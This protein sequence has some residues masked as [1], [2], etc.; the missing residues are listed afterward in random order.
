MNL[1]A[2]ITINGSEVPLNSNMSWLID[3]ERAFHEDAL[4]LM[5]ALLK[6]EAEN[7]IELVLRFL[8]VMSDGKLRIEEFKEASESDFL[9]L[10][11]ETRQ[12]LVD[13]MTTRTKASKQDSKTEN[14]QVTTLA[15]IA[16]G[17]RRGLTLAD[18]DRLTMGMWI[19]YC[20]EHN[21][22]TGVGRA[23]KGETRTAT[24]ADFDRF[25]GG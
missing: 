22:L 16:S 4:S 2:R 13:S 10:Y 8:F 24:Q 9:Y 15:M 6:G 3:Y 17:I 18:T 23:E 1:G 5:Y 12:I 20:I 7:P 19:D 11:Q 25:K 14:A 21:N